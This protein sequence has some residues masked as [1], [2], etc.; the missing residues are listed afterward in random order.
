[1]TLSAGVRIESLWGFRISSCG[2]VIEPDH[3]RSKRKVT[4][5][6]AFRKE[7]DWFLEKFH[8]IMSLSRV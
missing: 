1:M 6:I 3:L 8:H 2:T 7:H 4:I 5:V